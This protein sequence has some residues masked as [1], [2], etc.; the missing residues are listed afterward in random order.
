[1]I[2]YKEDLAQDIDRLSEELLHKLAGEDLPTSVI[3]VVACAVA[4]IKQ[5]P[6]NH[7]VTAIEETVKMFMGFMGYEELD[8]EE[9]FNATKH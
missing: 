5:L 9:F 8:E 7:H 1:M 4:L 6:E 3:A 2:E